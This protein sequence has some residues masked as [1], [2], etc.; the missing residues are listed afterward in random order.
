MINIFDVTDFGAVGDG[1]TDSTVAIQS[2]LDKAGE[3]KGEVVVPPGKYLCGD[4]QVPSSITLRGTHGWGY[5]DIGGSVLILK[6]DCKA[7]L[8]NVTGAHGS[9]LLGLQLLGENKGEGIH[10]ICLKWELYNGNGATFFDGNSETTAF[11]EDSLV[12]EDCQ[13]RDFSG[14]GIHLDHVFAFTLRNTHACHNRG[15]GV[16]IDG[17]DGW[18]SN[19]IFSSNGDYGIKGVNA[20][21]SITFTGNRIEWNN[22]GGF[23]FELGNTIAINSNHFDRNMG[24][25]IHLPETA[26]R[27]DCVISGNIFWR[28]G[29]PRKQPFENPYLS[30]HI[31]MGRCEKFLISNNVMKVGCDDGGGGT[32]SPDYGV[33]IH[34]CK[35]CIVKDNIAIDGV[36]KE[37]VHAENNV[38]CLIDV[39]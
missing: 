29:K 22:M 25:A 32:V 19:S 16:Y 3:V 20:T 27:V 38:N 17:W 5:G 14:N 35:N 31:Y 12:I 36:V 33:V 2:A 21:A 10:G 7:C 28:N 39:L 6:D 37:K 11:H 9:K 8:L 23:Y 26:E 15:S 24:P 13:V 1:K 18:I 4:L 34:S 30:A